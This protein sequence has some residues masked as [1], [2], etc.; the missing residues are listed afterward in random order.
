MDH[1]YLRLQTLLSFYSYPMTVTLS[2]HTSTPLAK[3]LTA[4][5]PSSHDLR[6]RLQ[7]ELALWDTRTA[8]AVAAGDLDQAAKAILAALDCERR[9]AGFGPQVLQLIKPRK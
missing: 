5:T 2:I 9:L 8:S 1:N 4:V 7:A 6:P 3:D